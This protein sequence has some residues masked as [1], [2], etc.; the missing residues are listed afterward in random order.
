MKSLKWAMMVVAVPLWMQVGAL[1]AACECGPN[2]PA[3]CK[4]GCK[5]EKVKEGSYKCPCGPNCPPNC[6]CGCQ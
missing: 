5:E 4:C 2:C 6:G 1:D 3:D